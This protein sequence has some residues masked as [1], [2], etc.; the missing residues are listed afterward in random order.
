MISLLVGDLLLFGD[1]LLL[2]GGKLLLHA[3]LVSGSLCD[4]FLFCLGLV[5]QLLLLLNCGEARSFLGLLKCTLLRLELARGE[6]VLET[7]ELLSKLEIDLLLLR[8]RSE[9]L[10]ILLLH[11]RRDLR[12]LL[13]TL[14]LLGG[15][16]DHGQTLGS[17][18]IAEL[19]QSC[20]QLGV[21]TEDT[22]R[23]TVRISL[24]ELEPIRMHEAVFGGAVCGSQD[25]LRARSGLNGFL[26][27]RGRS[28]G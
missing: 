1:E 16:Q 6:L 14:H 10:I 17:H 22:E 5:D 15:R 19:E 8:D 11:D 24:I 12:I 9:L 4:R 28:H 25:S 7:V 26:L 13:L 21:G 27:S 20:D 2:L 23:E 3:R 18:V